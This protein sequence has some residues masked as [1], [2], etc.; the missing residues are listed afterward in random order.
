[1]EYEEFKEKLTEKLRKIQ[2]DISDIQI[3]QFY[4]YMNILIN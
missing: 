2:I 4:D 1:M 3:K